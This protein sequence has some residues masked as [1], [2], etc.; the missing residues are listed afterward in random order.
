MP[1]LLNEPI[2]TSSGVSATSEAGSW[3]SLVAAAT[4]GLTF[5]SQLRAEVSANTLGWPEQSLRM[6]VQAYAPDTLDAQGLP[7][8]GA[9]PLASTQRVVRTEDLA[10]GVCVDLIQLAGGQDSVLVAWLEPDEADLDFDALGARPP[11]DAWF[12]LAAV[13]GPARIVLRSTL[14]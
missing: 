7:T 11:K 2:F 14:Q 4:L 1:P 9:R 6:I 5:V 8:L 3:L 12:G 10:R 13:T